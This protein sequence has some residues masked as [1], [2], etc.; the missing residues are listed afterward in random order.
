V[1]RCCDTGDQE[2]LRKVT[3]QSGEKAGKERP[4]EWSLDAGL[5]CLSA[6]DEEKYRFWWLSPAGQLL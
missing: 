1:D 5:G 6:K 3:R 2:Q 4:Q